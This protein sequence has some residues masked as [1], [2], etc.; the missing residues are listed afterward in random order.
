M[1]K[2][3]IAMPVIIGLATG[4]DHGRY[5]VNYWVIWFWPIFYNRMYWNGLM[6]F[7]QG[8]ITF[9]LLMSFLHISYILGKLKSR[10]L[11]VA[12]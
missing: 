10:E 2:L 6:S 1:L 11:I 12:G 3:F 7:D 8:V 9:T 5:N 4:Y